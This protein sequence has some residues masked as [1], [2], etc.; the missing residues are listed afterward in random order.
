MEFMPA[1]RVCA[2]GLAAQRAKMDVTISN[3]AN[4]NTTRTPEG[5]GVQKENHSFFFRAGR[6]KF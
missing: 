1:F 5:G 2:S 4:V 3:L 6:R